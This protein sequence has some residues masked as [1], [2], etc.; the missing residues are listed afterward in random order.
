M[1]SGRL[2]PED[3]KGDGFIHLRDNKSVLSLESTILGKGS[4]ALVYRF[5][6]KA[7]EMGYLKAGEAPK[8]GRAVFVSG[9]FHHLVLRRQGPGAT[10]DVQWKLVGLVAMDT[11]AKERV[12]YSRSKIGP[13]SE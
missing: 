11:L 4:T 2:Q 6:A 10:T 8:G 9:C 13:I 1:R 7:H 5:S 12:D 3:A